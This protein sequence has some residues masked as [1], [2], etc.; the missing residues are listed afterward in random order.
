MVGAPARILAALAVL[1]AAGL[2]RWTATRDLP[3]E[4]EELVFIGAGF[5]YAERMTPGRWRQIPDVVEGANQPPLVKLLYGAALRRAGATEPDW[6]GVPVGRPVPPEAE[7]AFEATRRL[8]A[9]G[10][11]LQVALA[12]LAAPL[13]GLWLVFDTAHTRYG[14]QA[15]LEGLAGL[16][17]LLAALLFERSLHRREPEG[18]LPEVVAPEAGPLLASAAALG[19]A[20]ASQYAFGLVVGLSILPFLLV[21]TRSRPGLRLAFAV[22]ALAVFAAADPAL[23]HRPID[24]LWNTVA[25]HLGEAKGTYAW[26]ATLPWWQPLAWLSRSSVPDGY[27]WSFPVTFLDRLL[28]AAAAL[29]APAAAARRPVVATW[30]LIGLVALAAWPI[31][32]PQD[33][34]LVRPALAICAGLGLSALLARLAHRPRRSGGGGL[35]LR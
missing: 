5:R 27:P 30:A 35:D 2:V 13:G 26:R 17:A 15:G 29:S 33:T 20:T 8:S 10:G 21:R 11:V 16:F 32:W 7:R 6:T 28:L 19:L 22:A 4:A 1:A 3:V 9:A 31:K 24:R 14:S 23:W 25:L 18:L 34:L 12:A